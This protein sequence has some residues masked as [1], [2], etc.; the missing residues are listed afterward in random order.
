MI[1][2]INYRIK[3]KLSFITMHK[4]NTP[5]LYT[6]DTY[7]KEHLQKRICFSN[8]HCKNMKQ[9]RHKNDLEHNFTR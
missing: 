8:K 7:S 9:T 6:S 2:I 1:L 3:T 5:T 4:R